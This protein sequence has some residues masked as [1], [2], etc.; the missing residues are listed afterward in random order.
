MSI[1]AIF[2]RTFIFDEDK[3]NLFLRILSSQLR[4]GRPYQDIFKSMLRSPNNNYRELAKRS[5]SPT[6]EFFA[7]KYDEHFEEDTAKLLVLAQKFNAVPDFIDYSINNPD[8]RA[9]SVMSVVVAPKVMEIGLTILF[10]VLFCALYIFNEQISADFADFSTSLPYSIGGL[11][12]ENYVWFSFVFAG[13]LATYFYN[14]VTVGDIRNRL[15]KVSFYR[16]SDAKF[17]IDLFRVMAIMTGGDNSQGTNIRALISELSLIFG[18]NR[19]RRHQF[20]VLRSEIVKGK[21]LH[22]ALSTSEILDPDSLELFRGL[23][24]NESISEIS[25]ASRA[26]ADLL[27]TKTKGEI[28]F[29]SKNVNFALLMYLAVAFLAVIQVSLG[30]GTDLFNT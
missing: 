23:A 1:K 5:L 11:F 30:G 9:L 12:V 14:Y 15:K 16:F 4:S 22:Q 25:K 18:R 27:C 17:A 7:S 20:S 29:F 2:T 8:K 19:Y 28:G 3:Q 26:V 24:P 6:S 10:T 13:F 21:P